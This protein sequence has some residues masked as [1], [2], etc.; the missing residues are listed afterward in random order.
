[1]LVNAKQ[2]HLLISEN[3]VALEYISLL[4]LESLYYYHIFLQSRI[5]ATIDFHSTFSTFK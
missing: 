1:M 4:D 2:V 5:C 3:T